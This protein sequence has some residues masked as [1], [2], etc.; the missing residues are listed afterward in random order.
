LWHNPQPPCAE[1]WEINGRITLFTETSELFL[2][3]DAKVLR[4]RIADFIEYWLTDKREEDDVVGKEYEV[5]P[6]L[7]VSGIGRVVRWWRSRIGDEEKGR[8]G[9]GLGMRKDERGKDDPI[10]M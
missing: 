10:D 7:T 2:L 1:K 4:D 8:E 5:K 9:A 6:T 3:A